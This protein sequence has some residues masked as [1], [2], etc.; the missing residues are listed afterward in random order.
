MGDLVGYGHTNWQT[1]QGHVVSYEARF[2]AYSIFMFA[3]ILH[4]ASF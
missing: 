4:H 3:Y 1:A 2:G